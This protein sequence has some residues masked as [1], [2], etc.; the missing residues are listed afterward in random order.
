MENAY[1]SVCYFEIH[2]FLHPYWNGLLEGFCSVYEKYGLFSLLPTA[3]SSFTWDSSQEGFP[4]HPHLP[5]HTPPPPVT[6]CGK[7][8]KA[9][10]ATVFFWPHS[11]CFYLEL[12]SKTKPDPDL[13]QVA[14]RT[15]VSTAKM[16]AIFTIVEFFGNAPLHSCM[17]GIGCGCC[18]EP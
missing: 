11:W 14:G 15:V 7:G 5:H 10:N 18:I 12:H 8:G 13:F 17:N 2:S 1:C 9:V 16:A 3:G 4:K 6:G